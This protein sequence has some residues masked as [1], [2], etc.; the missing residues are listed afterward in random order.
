MPF[1]ASQ[2]NQEDL[3][4]IAQCGKNEAVSTHCSPFNFRDME[5]IDC[6]SFIQYLLSKH[7]LRAVGV[8]TKLTRVRDD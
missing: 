8:E 3:W 6:V 5:L 7:S 2:A 4:K 1:H